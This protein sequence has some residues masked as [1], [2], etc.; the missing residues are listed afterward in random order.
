MELYDGVCVVYCGGMRDEKTKSGVIDYIGL[1][2]LRVLYFGWS[3]NER[4]WH[5]GTAG[6]TL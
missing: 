5:A 1:G 6:S 4:R 3:D 2:E